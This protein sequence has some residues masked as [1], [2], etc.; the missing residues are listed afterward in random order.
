MTENVS[1]KVYCYEKPQDNSA[2]WATL[3]NNHNNSPLETA[4]L[5]NG[6]AFGG[7]QWN[8]PFM[9]L[10]WMFMMRWMGGGNYCDGNCYT[11]GINETQR[12][13]A[14]LQN[15][16]LDNHNSDLI[17]AG[18][19][20]NEGAIREASTRMGCDIN[21]LSAAISNVRAS[22]DNVAAQTGFSAERVINAINLGDAN[23]MSKMQDCCCQQKQLILEQGYQS[24]LA[25]ERQTNI[26]GSKVDNNFASL[27]LQNCK[28]NGSVLERIGQL[29]N[30]VTQGFSATAYEAARHASESLR[31]GE[32][33][34]QRIIDSQNAGFQR[35]VD[36]MCA[37]ETQGLRDKLA[38]MSQEA[39]TAQILAKIGNNGG[40]G[41]CNSGCG[42]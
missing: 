18:I 41:G 7:N 4:A 14:N 30:G 11:Q 24:Q 21:A 15:Q 28:D 16:M 10:V 40:C 23:L 37:N 12:Q 34:T 20:G 3:M 33:N 39:Q 22:V 25:T 36:Q 19:K 2:L 42:I 31:A 8:S 27:Q 29:A 38:Q 13:V 1:E 17:M 5:L 6:G 26:L 35:I 9:Y 32:I